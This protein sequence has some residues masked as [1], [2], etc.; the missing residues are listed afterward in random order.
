MYLAYLISNYLMI[1]S[2]SVIIENCKIK[3][4]NTLLSVNQKQVDGRIFLQ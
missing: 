2:N 3:D 4:Q 1:G